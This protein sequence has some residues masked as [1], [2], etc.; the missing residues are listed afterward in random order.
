MKATKN[1][2]PISGEV[3]EGDE[4]NNNFEPNLYPPPKPCQIASLDNYYRT[5]CEKITLNQILNDRLSAIIDNNNNLHNIWKTMP[6][7]LTIIIKQN[8][9]FRGGI[10]TAKFQLN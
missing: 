2:A 3:N 6:D 1:F 8:V 9:R 7:S 5:K 10:C 4:K